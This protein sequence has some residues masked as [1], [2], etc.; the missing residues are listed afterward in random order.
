MSRR[1]RIAEPAAGPSTASGERSIR[2][3]FRL[4]A[5]PSEAFDELRALGETELR[6]RGA[7]RVRAH[8]KPGFPCRVSLVDAEPGEE[9]LLVPFAH[10][11]VDTPYRGAGPI[12]VRVDARTARPAANEVPEMIRSR[13]LSIRAYDAEGMLVASEVAE[14]GGLE[15]HVERFF[16]DPRIAYL[17]LHNARPGCF[18]CRV[19]R[20]EG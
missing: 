2:H 13:L 1:E 12:Y 17:H 7:R 20:V 6:A 11:D 10:H 4:V 3:P 18:N 8:A 5:L 14:G 16:S 19:E 9:V 15:E